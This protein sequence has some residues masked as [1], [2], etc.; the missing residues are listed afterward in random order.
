MIQSGRSL[1]SKIKN[2]FTLKSEIFRHKTS[3]MVLSIIFLEDKHKILHLSIFYEYRQFFQHRICSRDYTCY[4]QWPVTHISWSEQ[5]F[6][7]MVYNHYIIYILFFCRL[8]VPTVCL[9]LVI[10]GPTYYKVDI[11]QA[12][13]LFISVV[14]TLCNYHCILYYGWQWPILTMNT[15]NPHTHL[16]FIMTSIIRI[17][18]YW[19]YTCCMWR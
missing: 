11:S 18:G 9:F 10:F 1:L 4:S 16:L 7:Y 5:Y 6:V 13:A 3:H 12:G 17:C 2:T 8:N 19:D 15:N 14:H